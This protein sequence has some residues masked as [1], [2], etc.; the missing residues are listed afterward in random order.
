MDKEAFPDLFTNS[1]HEQS[2]KKTVQGNVQSFLFTIVSLNI[3]FLSIS[4][5]PEVSG[6]SDFESLLRD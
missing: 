3:S 1:G 4:Y 2:D 5:F 6:G